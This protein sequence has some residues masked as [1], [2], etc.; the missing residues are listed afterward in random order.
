MSTKCECFFEEWKDDLKG[1]PAF[2]GIK[3]VYGDVYWRNSA[4]K[5]FR[6]VE[7]TQRYSHTIS[8]FIATEDHRKL[9]DAESLAMKTGEPARIVCRVIL[10]G[11]SPGYAKTVISCVHCSKCAKSCS[12]LLYLVEFSS[13]FE[14]S[15]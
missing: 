4:Y 9:A 15:L 3:P 2:W 14:L 10:P 6:Q 1:E 7:D 13:R 8:T 5:N 12:L 11:E